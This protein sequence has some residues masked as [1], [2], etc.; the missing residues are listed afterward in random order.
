MSQNL[1]SAIDAIAPLPE[2]VFEIE[3]VYHDEQSTFE[4]FVHVIEKDPLLTA[5]ILRAVNAPLYGLK[6]HISSI[7]QAISLLG[8]AVVRTLAL[9]NAINRSFVI[10]LSPYAITKSAFALAS[11]RT[12][13]LCIH[14]LIR[15]EPTWLHLLAPSAFLIHLGRVVIAKWL[16]ENGCPS[17]LQL[18]LEHHRLLDD[19]EREVCGFSAAEVSALLFER[20]RFDP[21]MVALIRHSCDPWTLEGKER[22]QAVAL[23]VMSVSFKSDGSMDE[24]A[25]ESLYRVLEREGLY[26][27]DYRRALERIRG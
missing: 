3:R 1:L 18:A 13:A 22:R 23:H 7:H 17:A 8:R 25:I 14:W 10:N 4:A 6:A 9:Q 27:A 16:I 20:W 24:E 15:R 2:S 19:A 5:D 12:L 21:A 11:E 26:G